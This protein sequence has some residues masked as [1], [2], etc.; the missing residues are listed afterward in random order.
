MSTNPKSIPVDRCVRVPEACELLGVS[1]TTLWKLA[2]SGKLTATRFGGVVTFR[3]SVIAAFIE[4][5]TPPPK[6]EKAA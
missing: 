1:R 6:K 4:N 5:H 3:A 2:K